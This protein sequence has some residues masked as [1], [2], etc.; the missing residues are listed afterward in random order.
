MDWRLQNVSLPIINEYNILSITENY[1]KQYITYNIYT[2]YKVYRVSLFIPT[3]HI[4]Q[5]FY[6]TDPEIIVSCV[7]QWI[8]DRIKKI[9]TGQP[10]WPSGGFSPGYNPGDS[11]SAPVS[12]SLHGAYFSLCLCVCVS[13]CVCHE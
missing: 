1:Y 10:R 6:H 8:S 9:K 13:L 5:H 4:H 12:G 7:K 2:L 11:G 3:H